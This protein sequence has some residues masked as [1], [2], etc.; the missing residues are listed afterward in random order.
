MRI[1]PGREKSL[2]EGTEP[3]YTDIR[4]IEVR[5]S[6]GRVVCFVPEAMR[7]F[8]SGDDSSELV[9]VLTRASSSAEWVYVG[10]HNV[11]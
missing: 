4:Q 9:K 11:G 6:D 5:Y 10:E 3:R 2:K 7:E 1:F 8:F